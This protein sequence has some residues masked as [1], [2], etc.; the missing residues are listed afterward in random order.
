MLYSC[1][2][3]TISALLVI[4]ALILLPIDLAHAASK[5]KASPS[6]SPDRPLD[7]EP[8]RNPTRSEQ[9][10]KSTAK[11]SSL[12]T[13]PKVLTKGRLKLPAK[14]TIDYIIYTGT[15][16]FLFAPEPRKGLCIGLGTSPADGFFAP[17]VDFDRLNQSAP[18]TYYG[19][20]AVVSPTKSVHIDVAPESAGLTQVTVPGTDSGPTVVVTAGGYTIAFTTYN[21]TVITAP[22]AVQGETAAGPVA[23]NWV[24]P[25]PPEPTRERLEAGTFATG[26]YVHVRDTRQTWDIP[27]PPSSPPTLTTR[28]SDGAEVVTSLGSRVISASPISSRTSCGS[29][30]GVRRKTTSYLQISC[31]LKTG[32]T[33]MELISGTQKVDMPVIYLQATDGKQLGLAFG[34]LVNP[35]KDLTIVVFDA[36]GT[37]LERLQLTSLFAR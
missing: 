13:N 32:A 9:T 29:Q 23:L 7:G 16:T 19:F 25:V 2:R 35:A 11:V 26:T 24:T 28:V 37:E 5:K 6:K 27:K 3:R 31:D 36:A 30:S 8:L 12:V 34:E 10:F 22:T 21:D 15:F 4:S 1:S 14:K 17:C 20:G 33:R 18:Y